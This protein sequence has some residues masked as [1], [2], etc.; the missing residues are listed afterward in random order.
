MNL[1]KE[2]FQA[3]KQRHVLPSLPPEEE[4]ALLRLIPINDEPAADSI[5]PR[6]IRPP[7][8]QQKFVEDEVSEILADDAAG[9]PGSVQWRLD[10]DALSGYPFTV[11][12]SGRNLPLPSHGLL[13]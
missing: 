7:P 3:L 9:N 11:R 5:G 10:E 1:P 12:S 6:E 8:G 13:A 4:E 2:A